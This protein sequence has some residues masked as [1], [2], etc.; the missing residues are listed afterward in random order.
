[1]ER[2]PTEIRKGEIVEAV[3]KI[4]NQEGVQAVTIRNIAENISITEGAIY[5]H[6]K[7]KA[8]ILEYLIDDFEKHLAGIVEDAV[9]NCTN[10]IDE[11]RQIMKT[12]LTMIE[13][14]KGILFPLTAESVH[15][16]N[17]SLKIKIS[18]VVDNYKKTIKN[19]LLTAKKDKMIRQDINL[20]AAS[21]TFFGLI[22]AGSV[23]SA[24]S[25]SSASLVD[26]FPA[27]WDI[28]ITGISS[29]V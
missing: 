28:F 6:F 10:P 14:K 8:E 7:D 27:I 5:R 13:K 4:M 22:Q 2:K 23:Q 17:K 25:E 21:L 3:K 29:A 20:E 18:N 1:M 16:G 19:I 15:F 12:H 9:K 11:L 24:L 26:R